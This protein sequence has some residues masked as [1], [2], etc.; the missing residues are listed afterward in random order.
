MLDVQTRTTAH[1]QAQASPHF[2]PLSASPAPPSCNS[3][4][5]LVEEKARFSVKYSQRKVSND[6]GSPPGRPDVLL[7]GAEYPA[8][9]TAHVWGPHPPPWTRGTLLPFCHHERCCC[10]LWCKHLLETPLSF[11]GGRTQ[12]WSPGLSETAAPGGGGA[13][14]LP[15]PPSAIPFTPHLSPR[16]FV[17]APGKESAC[18][19]RGHQVTSFRSE[20]C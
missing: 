3:T 15:P 4:V 20:L 2:H 16:R 5:A 1:V 13:Q 14:P 6:Q 12:E 19:A 10:E 18:L 11:L 9:C 7:S 17:M 8:V